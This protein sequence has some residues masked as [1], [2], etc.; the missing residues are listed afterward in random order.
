VI[1]H[2]CHC[3]APASWG[4]GFRAIDGLDG[5]WFCNAHKSQGRD[6]PVFTSDEILD[7]IPERFRAKCE[8]CPLPLDIREKGV[9][10]RVSGW[11]MNR[12]GGG[13]HG[14]SLPER[15][16]RWAHHE[17]IR[18]AIRGGGQKSLFEAANVTPVNRDRRGRLWPTYSD[19]VEE[20]D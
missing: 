1:E 11:V 12:E 5:I 15:E 3:G 7:H 16:N 18:D 17:C 2:R 4:F 19:D 6:I 14:I 8:F 9:H 20:L 10:Q 13:G